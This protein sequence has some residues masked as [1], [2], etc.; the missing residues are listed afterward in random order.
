MLMQGKEDLDN[1]SYSEKE[2]EIPIKKIKKQSKMRRIYLLMKNYQN[3][4]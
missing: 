1:E 3:K 2:K 4:I